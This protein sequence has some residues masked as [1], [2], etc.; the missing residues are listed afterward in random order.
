MFLICFD[1]PGAFFAGVTHMW[2]SGSL[3]TGV[4]SLVHTSTAPCAGSAPIVSTLVTHLVDF[5]KN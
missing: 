5:V 1:F 2:L 3:L 4:R